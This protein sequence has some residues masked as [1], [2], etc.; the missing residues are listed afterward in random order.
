MPISTS[1]FAPRF[2]FTLRMTRASSRNVGKLYIEHY[3]L[4]TKNLRCFHTA[5]AT[6]KDVDRRSLAII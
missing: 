1:F 5:T 4:S 2:T 6:E 3:K